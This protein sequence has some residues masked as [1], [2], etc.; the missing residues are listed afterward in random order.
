MRR[1]VRFAISLILLAGTATPQSAWAVDPELVALL[2]NAPVEK[3]LLENP[4]LAK[5]ILGQTVGSS[6]DLTRFAFDHASSPLLSAIKHNLK[7]LAGGQGVLSPVSESIPNSSDEDFDFVVSAIHSGAS[8]RITPAWK[9]TQPSVR[10]TWG[11]E[12]WVDAALRL[13]PEQRRLALGEVEKSAMDADTKIFARLVLLDEA[14]WLSYIH[15]Q[16]ESTRPETW[17]YGKLGIFYTRLPDSTKEK[18]LKEIRRK[19]RSG[20][21]GFEGTRY[22]QDVMDTLIL[23]LTDVDQVFYRDVRAGT[24]PVVALQN[25][26]NTQA[27]YWGR[28][29]QTPYGAE[30]LWVVAKTFRPNW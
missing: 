30:D 10:E 5:Q 24:P 18:I 29:W 27:F 17:I 16:M 11:T 12:S 28:N 15:K 25:Y 7:V 6:E 19:Y 20:Q 23:G 9:F 13:S 2:F 14:Q 4:D 8:S 26:L 22:N 21:P 1:I 3:Q